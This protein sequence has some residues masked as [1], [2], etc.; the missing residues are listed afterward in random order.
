MR[1]IRTACRKSIL[2][3][4]AFTLQGLCDWPWLYWALLSHGQSQSGLITNRTEWVVYQSGSIPS[5]SG[6]HVEVSLGKILNTKLLQLPWMCVNEFLM[7]RLALRRDVTLPVMCECVYE[8][9]NADLCCKVL[10]V[11]EKTRKAL[12]KYSPFTIYHSGRPVPLWQKCSDTLPSEAAVNLERDLRSQQQ[13]HL[14]HSF[15]HHQGLDALWSHVHCY[16]TWILDKF[17][18]C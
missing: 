14:E 3:S 18:I 10:W 1:K 8:W 4:K 17:V 16:K 5:S 12:Y 2:P 11:V 7:S 9:M 15:L 6:L 13:F